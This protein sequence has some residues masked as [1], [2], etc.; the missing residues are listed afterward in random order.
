M[1]AV[2]TWPHRTRCQCTE[3][4]LRSYKAWCRQQGERKDAH[5]ALHAT[6]GSCLQNLRQRKC[7]RFVLPG[8]QRGTDGDGFGFWVSGLFGEKLGG[9]GSCV[10]SAVLVF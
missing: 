3:P 9:G 10:C 8:A 2:T 6:P 1:E 4:C 7:H 5:H